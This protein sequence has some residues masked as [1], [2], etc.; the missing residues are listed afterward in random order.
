MMPSEL[1]TERLRLRRWEQS[2]RAPFAAMNADPKVMEHFPAPLSASESDFF[3]DLIEQHFEDHGFGLWAIEVLDGEPFIGF[4][5]LW[6]ASFDAHFTPAVE[7]GWRV[8]HRFWGRGYAPEAARGVVSDG[9]DRLGLPEIVSFTAA[10]N[11]RS[12]RVMEKLGMRH[13]ASDDFDHPSVES[14][15]PLRRHVLYRLSSRR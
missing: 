11:T 14:A 2:D 12:R 15:S 1:R 3:I 8:D 6:P 10:I 7:V 4:V 13:E 5:G 9:F